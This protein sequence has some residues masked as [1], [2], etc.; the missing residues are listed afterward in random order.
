MKRG[1]RWGCT[2]V[3]DRPRG[4]NGRWALWRL[5]GEGPGSFPLALR[6]FFPDPVIF[7][8]LQPVLP[9]LHS[10]TF[11]V[12]TMKLSSGEKRLSCPSVDEVT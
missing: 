5:V 3:S 1:R 12:L 2:S 6:V 8:L 10:F 7:S 4:T 11:L 9:V